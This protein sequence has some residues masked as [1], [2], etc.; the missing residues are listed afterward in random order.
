MRKSNLKRNHQPFDDAVSRYRAFM[1]K[2]IGAQRVISTAQEKR[3]VAE[4]VLRRLCAN[5]EN[6]VDEHIVDCVNCDPS[7]LSEHFGVSIPKHPTW[8][9]CHALIIGDGYTDFRS[10]GDLKGK[11][12]RLIPDDS[13]PFLAV[14]TTQ[15]KRID[16]VYK[17]RNYLAHY[18]KKSRASLFHVYQAEYKMTRF[19]EPGQFLLAY[20]ARR[21]WMYFDSFA[22][23]SKEMLAWCDS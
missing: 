21:L 23:A 3:D 1:E 19:M 4:S 20:D 16:E 10:F 17:I 12:K 8:D 15:A 7:Q 18:S 6:F 22:S 14:T 5:W 2:I 9:L 11:S 13:N